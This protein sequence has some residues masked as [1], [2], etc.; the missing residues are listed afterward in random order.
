M[1]IEINYDE[2]S[3]M[4]KGFPKIRKLGAVSPCGETTPFVFNNR[5][6]RLELEDTSRGLN[7]YVGVAA[8]IRDRETGEVLSHFAE[9]CYYHS[10]YQEGD[11]VYV[12]GVK[13]IPPLYSG[14]TYM[15]YES[16]DLIHWSGR[17][18]LSNPGWKYYNSS[19]TRGP[20][21]YVLCM[22]AGE[23]AE[24]VGPHPFTCFFATSKDLIH[25]DFME[26]E[27]GFSK[28]RYMGGPWFHYSKGWY[29]LISVTS[30]PCERYTNYIYRTKDF[31]TWEV[32]GYNPILMPD[33]EDRKI[34][35]Y[36]YDMSAELLKEIREGF[37]SSNSDIDM[38]DWNGRT[39]ITYIVGNQ[40]GFY[41]LAEAEY[42]GTVDEFLAS[43]FE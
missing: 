25:W 16:K 19:L 28:D 30:L 14:D 13:S 3:I 21:G 2:K 11:M 37:I 7:S 26:Y 39:L 42:E 29:Y 12:I 32:G 35:P 5:V 9:E 33:E 31:D 18:L 23:P 34:S 43:Y 15:I 38:C 40:R 4:K 22:E 20:E 17:E 1:H 8:L 41:Y 27:K 6:Y 36:C 24:H 10:L